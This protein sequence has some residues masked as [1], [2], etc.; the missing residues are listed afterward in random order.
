MTKPAFLRLHRALGLT[1]ALFLLAQG[2]TGAMLAWREPLARLI[3]PAAMVRRT[4]PAGGDLPVGEALARIARARPEL[5]VSR[6]YFAERADGAWFLEMRDAQARARYATADPG[7]GH[8]LKMGGAAAFPLQAALLL[9]Y[10]LGLGP[11]GS[12]LIAADGIALLLLALSG[13]GQWWPGRARIGPALAIRRRLPARLLLRQCH[14]TAGVLAA[15][16]LFLLAATGAALALPDAFAA[17]DAPAA[18]RSAPRP[19]PAHVD[20]ALARARTAF[21]QARLRDVRLVPGA[22][23]VNFH[24]PERGPRAVHQVT[25]D[26]TAMALGPVQP[27][28][29][30]TALWMTMLPIHTGEFAGLAGRLAMT[31]AAVVLALLAMSGLAIGLRRT[32]R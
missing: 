28:R 6:F 11:A 30:N 2:V 15:L 5:A 17:L 20:A 19:E 16:F 13:L 3:D 8:V 21:P 23:R 12:F 31:L 7:D 9:H 25:V 1:M 24:A 27:A 29:D 18:A 22:I 10:Q 26:T 14:R 32:R 4:D